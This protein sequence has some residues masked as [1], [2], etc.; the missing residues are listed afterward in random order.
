MSSTK[1]L[2]ALGFIGA[3]LSVALGAF[4]A[5]ALEAQLSAKM[6][7]VYQTGVQYQF[8]HSLGLVCV[9]SVALR[10]PDAALVHWG[11]WLMAGG[12]VLFSGSL[13]GLSLASVSWL[14]MVTPAGGVMLILAWALLA[15]GVIREL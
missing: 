1:S 10:M 8:Y 2:L 5:H 7:A 14:G 4:G 9:G 12:V 15:A 11:G 3:M 6:L 13:Y